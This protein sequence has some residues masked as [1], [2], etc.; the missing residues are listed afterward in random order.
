MEKYNAIG[1][2]YVA[3]GILCFAVILSVIGLLGWYK[4]P[5]GTAVAMF[6]MAGLLMLAVKVAYFAGKK[7]S[8][9]N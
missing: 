7:E 4:C 5:M 2:K 8:A 6:V 1:F 9:E 3:I